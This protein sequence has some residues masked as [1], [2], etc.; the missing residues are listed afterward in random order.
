MP[1]T[2]HHAAH[3]FLRFFPGL[4]TFQTKCDDPD[5][6]ESDGIRARLTQVLHGPH[7]RHAGKLEVLNE[8]GAGIYFSVNETDGQGRRLENI[9]KL[10]ALVV[11]WDHGAPSSF[12][13]EPSLLV[14]SSPGKLQAYWLLAEPYVAVP[15]TIRRWKALEAGMVTAMGGDQGAKLVTQVLR[16]PGYRNNKYPSRPMVTQ[17]PRTGLLTKYDMRS[18]EKVWE[19]LEV[20]GENCE[21]QSAILPAVYRLPDEATRIR[22]YAAWL[23]TQT[24]PP[25]GKSARNPWYYARAKA[26]VNDF[27][28]DDADAL[29]E[30]IAAHS[31]RHHGIAAYDEDDAR[32]LIRSARRSTSDLP[33]GC[34]YAAASPKAP[35]FVPTIASGGSES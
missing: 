14:E 19:P 34:K 3:D 12:A 32:R 21:L 13:R 11:E 33:R 8:L 1:I 26:G 2:N 29:A 10:R 16:V 22:R 25:A 17:L 9:T 5:L 23:E 31:E 7:E 15:D 20:A 18:L 6:N 28:I 24:P 30:V 4:H 35:S 27:A